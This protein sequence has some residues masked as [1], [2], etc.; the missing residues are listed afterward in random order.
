[1]HHASKQ[2]ES[3]VRAHQRAWEHYERFKPTYVRY[4]VEQRQLL[5]KF[6]P[7]ADKPESLIALVKQMILEM[8]PDIWGLATPHL[9]AQELA[10]AFARFV[11]GHT[12]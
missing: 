10:D 4:A 7:L 3:R 6:P 5:L 1:M 8:D 2:T 12:L 11:V 9:S